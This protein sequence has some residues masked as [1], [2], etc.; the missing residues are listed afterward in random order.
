MDI[1]DDLDNQIP[2]IVLENNWNTYCNTFSVIRPPVSNKDHP[3]AT[4]SDDPQPCSS[5]GLKRP[6]SD[7]VDE[8]NVNAIR[9]DINCVNKRYKLPHINGRTS[10]CQKWLIWDHL[11]FK[12]GGIHGKRLSGSANRSNGSRC[13]YTGKSNFA[14]VFV[15]TTSR[16]SKI[17]Y[18]E[19]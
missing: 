8:Y 10:K 6:R 13:E 11:I 7:S 5:S 3:V 14:P 4:D 9:L 16:T 15:T 1:D 18:R 19:R 2:E 12:K 17:T